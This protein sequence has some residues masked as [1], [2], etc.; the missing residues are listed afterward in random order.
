[1][2]EDHNSVL[3]DRLLFSAWKNK[4]SVRNNRFRLQRDGQLYDL[5]SDREELVD[6][7]KLYPKIARASCFFESLVGR[8]SVNNGGP[9]SRP[10]T[11]GHLDESVINY[12]LGMLFHTAR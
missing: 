1:M 2:L 12:L 8:D 10:I 5:D 9:E 7:A 4:A 6:V 3:P 11:L